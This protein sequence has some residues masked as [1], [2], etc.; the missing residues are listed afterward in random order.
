MTSLSVIFFCDW[1]DSNPYISQ[2]CQ[3]LKKELVE[4]EVCTRSLIWLHKVIG[5]AHKADIVHFHT[6]HRFFVSRNPIYYWIKF[7]LFTGQLY[8]LRLLGISTVLTIHEWKDKLSGGQHDISVRKA[9][10][11]ISIFSGIVTHCDSTKKQV[12]EST[13]L[14]AHVVDNEFSDKF[15]TIPHGNYIHVYENSI[16]SLDARKKLDLPLDSINFLIFGGIHVSK[17][18]ISAIE[19]FLSLGNVEQLNARLVVAG[20]SNLE[21]LNLLRSKADNNPSISL[22]VDSN[23]YIPDSDVQIYMNACDVVL[24]PYQVFTTSGVA[25][26]AM[27]FS[28][29]CIAPNSGFFREVFH[30]GG[31]FLY[32]SNEDCGLRNAMLQAVSDRHLLKS[33]GQHNFNKALSWN[34]S[35]VAGE[36]RKVYKSLHVDS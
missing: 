21:M 35:Y 33:K 31:G 1:H 7:L 9:N 10:I 14:G 25:L 18:I 34:W 32:S 12:L 15:F 13:C 8:C 22:F 36:T 11:L 16:N 4:V 27:S 19:T 3:A 30:E 24:L 5:S 28:K 2:L 23:N 29:P 17:G 26:L 6:L 20:K